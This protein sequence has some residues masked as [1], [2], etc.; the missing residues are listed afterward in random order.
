MGRWGPAG[1][2]S[3]GGGGRCGKGFKA[4]GRV[5]GEILCAWIWLPSPVLSTPVELQVDG[6]PRRGCAE[7]H[8]APRSCPDTCPSSTPRPTG[9]SPPEPQVQQVLNPPGPLLTH[10]T[11]LVF[12]CSSAFTSG[13]GQPQQ[14]GGSRQTEGRSHTLPSLPVCCP[15][16]PRMAVMETAPK[17]GREVESARERLGR[18]PS[19]SPG[20]QSDSGC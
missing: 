7:C 20:C 15:Q 3:R 10:P 1:P 19:S 5:S 12:C 8:Q 14:T 13:D 2:G 9:V 6:T 4:L 11:P 16:Q 17:A 18:H